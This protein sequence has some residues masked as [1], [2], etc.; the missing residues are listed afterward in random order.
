L[1]DRQGSAFFI[2]TPNGKNQFYDLVYGDQK[3]WAGAIKHPEWFHVAYKASETSYVD[4]KELQAAR[5]VMTQDEYDQEFEC[6]FEASVKGAVY[7]REL[8][9]AREQGRI[10]RVPYDP[11]LQVDTD[12]DLGMGDAT[13]IWFSQRL[14][15]GEV[16]LIDYYEHSGYGL[17]HYRQVLNQKPYSYGTH[18][19]PFDIQVRELG[20]GNSRLDTA[21][22]MGL[23]FQVS[24]KVE[25]IDDRIHASRMLLPRCWFDAEKC[26]RGIECLKNYAW[27]FN[28]R[29]HEFTKLP[30]HNWASHGADAFGGL[31]FRDY[32]KRRSPEREAAMAVA[33]AQ[34][35]DKEPFRW[36]RPMGSRGGY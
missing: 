28:T 14:Y 16:R 18:W 5:A 25:S 30:V 23:H 19:A 12:W 27:D 3:D 1:T 10:T 36:R 4:A 8:Q 20:S 9:A 13:A 15:T 22:Q 33:R 21:R 24:P 34:R 26:E 17:D 7:A 32:Q 35:D 11:A 2:G 29:I 6:S 31:A